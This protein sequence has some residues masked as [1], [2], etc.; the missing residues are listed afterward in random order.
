MVR[1]CYVSTTAI[2]PPLSSRASCTQSHPPRLEETIPYT[3]RTWAYC[4]SFKMCSPSESR[5]SQIDTARI[6]AFA[7]PPYT[8]ALTS[9]PDDFVGP[10]F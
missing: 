8:H 4:P 9:P 5:K 3:P 7:A 1:G 2:P 6:I 10:E